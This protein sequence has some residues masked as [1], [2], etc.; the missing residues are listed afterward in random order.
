M[1]MLQQTHLNFLIIIILI[2]LL[3]LLLFML[4]IY[5]TSTPNFNNK[6]IFQKPVDIVIM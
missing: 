5:N 3:L 6:H 4:S 2:S 1:L